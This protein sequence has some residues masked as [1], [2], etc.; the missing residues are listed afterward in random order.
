M[1][2]CVYRM[3]R[4]HILDCLISVVVISSPQTRTACKIQE[5]IWALSLLTEPLCPC[6]VFAHKQRSPTAERNDTLKSPYIIGENM[7]LIY[8][9]IYRR[10]CSD[11]RR[12]EIKWRV[13]SDIP[14]GI[15]DIAPHFKFLMNFLTNLASNKRKYHILFV[16]YHIWCPYAGSW[17][18]PIVAKIAQRWR[19]SGTLL[20]SL[21]SW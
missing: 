2:V 5:D 13:A 9:W 1:R 15:D 3:N 14:E 10:R 8:D 12:Y 11:N 7:K 18:K 6:T 16:L 4:R 20:E 21:S 17:W 19:I